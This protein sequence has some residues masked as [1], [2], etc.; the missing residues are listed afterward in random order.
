MK[1]NKFLLNKQAQ[2]RH[3]KNIDSYLEEILS[4]I[5]SFIQYDSERPLQYVCKYLLPLNT[6]IREIFK[7]MPI[8]FIDVSSAV[9][10]RIKGMMLTYEMINE[11][12]PIIKMELYRVFRKFIILNINPNTLAKQIK[13]HYILYEGTENEIYKAEEFISPRIKIILDNSNLTNVCINESNVSKIVNQISKRDTINLGYDIIAPGSLKLSKTPISFDKI[14][15]IATAFVMIEH[16]YSVTTDL[17]LE[18]IN[19]INL[20]N[21]NTTINLENLEQVSKDYVEN[22]FNT[23]RRARGNTNVWDTTYTERDKEII[24]DYDLEYDMKPLLSCYSVFVNLLSE[25]DDRKL[26]K[27]ID[28]GLINNE[29][30]TYYTITTNT[31]IN[32][33]NHLNSGFKNIYIRIPYPLN[34]F[35]IAEILLYY[36]SKNLDISDIYLIHPHAYLKICIKLLKD[37]P[38]YKKIF[39]DELEYIKNKLNYITSISTKEIT[40]KILIPY[41]KESLNDAVTHTDEEV[42]IYEDVSNDILKYYNV[43]NPICY[44]KYFNEKYEDEYSNENIMECT[45]KVLCDN[46]KPNKIKFINNDTDDIYN[47]DDI[48]HSCNIVYFEKHK[49]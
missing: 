29:I 31:L 28:N 4:F 14:I 5:Y 10:N 3:I 32:T 17:E 33:N 36:L 30:S 13:K 16:K 8:G 46:V 2:Y 6:L 25:M 22:S 27:C 18:T 11:I 47:K 9:T 35:G 34:D 19:T 38:E 23:L 37:F 49:F 24:K 39:K 12:R 44:T 20:D 26:R 15:S 43:L 42:T 21:N 48:L 45:C 40:V 41:F 1:K 7:D